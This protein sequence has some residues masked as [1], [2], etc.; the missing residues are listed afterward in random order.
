MIADYKAYVKNVGVLELPPG[1]NV[2]RQI[3]KNIIARQLAAYWWVLALMALTLLGLGVML[4]RV[5]RRRR[6]ETTSQ[7]RMQ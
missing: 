4:W 7:I 1:Y 2:Q 5:M 6:P 3:A